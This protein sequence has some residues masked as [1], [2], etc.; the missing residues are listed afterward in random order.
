MAESTEPLA[1]IVLDDGLQSVAVRLVSL[2]PQEGYYDAEIVIR[3]DFVN[4]TV[5]TG[6]DA[7]DISE[8]G[9][10]LD[11]VEEADAE[12]GEDEAE[13]SGDWPREGRTAY[14]TFITEDPYV[15]EVHDAP[16]TQ[17]SVRIPLDL[18]SDWIGE[19]RER[20]DTVRR[21]LGV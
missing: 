5:R 17:I 9:S 12:A 21:T 13:F 15:I 7:A 1:L 2:M 4:A 3:S 10:L 19:V 8:W 14:L 16:G 11:V 6:F 20:L 18:K